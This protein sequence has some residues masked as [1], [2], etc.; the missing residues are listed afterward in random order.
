MIATQASLGLS[1]MHSFDSKM[2]A[3][4]A[5]TDI[6]P[7]QWV[8]VGD[9]YKLNDFNRARFLRINQTDGTTCTF[10]V[11]KNPGKNRAPE[12]YHS[13]GPETAAIDVYSLGNLFYMLLQK[14][15]PFLTE[16]NKDA[17][18]MI[19]KGYRPKFDKAVWYSKNKYDQSLKTAMVKCHQQDPKD[20][21]SALEIAD[22]LK[23]ELE[24]HDPG[25]LASWGES[26]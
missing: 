24:K 9:R 19:K 15:W 3:S 8:K 13:H 4:V 20:R 10:T 11:P 2:R 26:V 6:S 16:S 5:H 7:G 21:A 22:F 12:E 1:A 18:K 23:Q 14:R 25:L 17:R